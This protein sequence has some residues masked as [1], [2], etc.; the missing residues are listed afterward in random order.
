MPGPTGKCAPSGRPDAHFARPGDLLRFLGQAARPRFP[1]TSQPASACGCGGSYWGKREI[2]NGRGAGTRGSSQ[3]RALCELCC[4]AIQGVIVGAR[5]KDLVD[6]MGGIS[7]R[8]LRRFGYYRLPL[9]VAPT[10][11]CMQRGARYRVVD[12]K[13]RVGR[14]TQQVQGAA[15]FWKVRRG[16]A[17]A[18]GVAIAE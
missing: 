16:I 9:H 3:S 18:R 15:R 10:M 2:W 1:S 7:A 6:R 17:I 4:C 5:H 12:F 14:W 11:N 8:L 13:C